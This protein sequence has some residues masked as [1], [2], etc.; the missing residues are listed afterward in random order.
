M[1]ALDE[2]AATAVLYNADCPI[3]RIEIDHHRRLAAREGLD[4]TFDDLN[5]DDARDAWG[6]TEQEAARRLHVRTPG[7]ILTGFDAN[8]ALWR[9]L[10][11][12]RILARIA[13][14]PG[15]RQAGAVIYDRIFGPVV[16][17]MHERR[18]GR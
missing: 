15:L 9:A 11:R 16:F 4:V 10:P 3:C 14:L 6:V 8:L 5:D 18:K 17:A 2:R 13:G 7:G 1:S 12:W